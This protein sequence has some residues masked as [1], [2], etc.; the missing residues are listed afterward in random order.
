MVF[1]PS[2]PVRVPDVPEGL[3]ELYE[4]LD[5]EDDDHVTSKLLSYW[6]IV[7]LVDSELKYQPVTN[8]IGA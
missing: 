2:D 1:D 3:W 5:D 8:P 4:G 6:G 7:K